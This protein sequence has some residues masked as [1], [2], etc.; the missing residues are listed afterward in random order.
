MISS[1][2]AA[3]IKIW[4]LLALFT[5]RLI[6][7]YGGLLRRL[8][9]SVCWV[10]FQAYLSTDFIRL[11]A[12]SS[13]EINEILILH[14]NRTMTLQPA[15]SRNSSAGRRFRFTALSEDTE[16]RMDTEHKRENLSLKSSAYIIDNRMNSSSVIT[17]T[18][19]RM[20]CFYLSVCF[21]VR[22]CD[23]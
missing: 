12:S 5:A 20:L 15:A 16:D 13:K 18:D 21:S 19:G 17:S 22:F 7:I 2:S 8:G 3:A 23:R 4:G 1:V 10:A 6:E 9:D 14:R 11:F